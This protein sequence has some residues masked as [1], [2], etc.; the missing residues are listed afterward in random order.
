MMMMMMMMMMTMII[1][2]I[3]IIMS[4]VLEDHQGSVIVGGRTITA[5]CFANDLDV[6]ADKYEERAVLVLLLSYIIVSYIQLDLLEPY[7]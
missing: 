7:L 3:I 4:D 1:I 5:L 2:I 6:T